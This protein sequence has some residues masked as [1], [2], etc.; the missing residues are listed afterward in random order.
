MLGT[1]I[2]FDLGTSAIVAYVE[3]KGIKINEPSV[4]AYDTFDEK[5]KAIGT[6]AY[7]MLG[8][9]PDS[10]TVIQPIKDGYIYDYDALQQMMCYFIQ[11]ICL[12]RIFKPNVLAC[13]PSGTSE[14]D[15]KSVTD[16]LI[17][18][19]A[20]RACVIE[21]PLAAALGAGVDMKN[22]NGVLIV[23]IGGG[24]T[25]IAIVSRGI[26]AISDSVSVAGNSF[27]EAVCRF[28]RRERDTIIGKSTAERVKKEIGAA[29]FL[30]AELAIRAV[31]KDYITKLPKNSELTS[32][33]IF[34]CIREQL[35]KI[36]DS[37]KHLLSITQPELVADIMKN[38]M[39][40]T[41]GGANIRGIDE[42]FASKLNFNVRC[43]ENPESCVAKGLGV[44]LDDI[45]ILE[46]NGYIFRSYADITEF[47]EN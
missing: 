30:D 36:T 28:M 2:G 17:S 1:K 18:S 16:L 33:D 13:V 12:N 24:T 39:I 19:G 41:G 31:G 46:E 29:K 34:L 25:D 5:V 27:D 9:N 22:P 3:D 15:K 45:K 43:A 26:V 40:I 10:L 44:M 14:I 4:I 7:K 23:D 37:I 11:K 6:E 8:K 35:E 38:G 32:T 47:E 42:Y 20:A 21:E